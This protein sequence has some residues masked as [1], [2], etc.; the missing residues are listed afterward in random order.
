MRFFRTFFMLRILEI[1]KQ[2]NLESC[3][4][5]FLVLSKSIN[6]IPQLSLYFF[7]LKD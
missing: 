2:Q 6:F 7:I 4:F 5:M 1:K 3:C